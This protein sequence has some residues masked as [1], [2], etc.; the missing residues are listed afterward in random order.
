MIV[1]TDIVFSAHIIPLSA[2]NSLL[3]ALIL[4]FLPLFLTFL[5][6]I[7]NLKY[8][9]LYMYIYSML[10]YHVNILFLKIV[11]QEDY[12]GQ[13]S[14]YFRDFYIQQKKKNEKK[15]VKK[16]ICEYTRTKKG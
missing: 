12:D 14:Q 1:I 13:K 9:I 4:T 10:C 15:K 16:K 3:S 8:T 11:Y 2:H 7:F 6:T 5:P